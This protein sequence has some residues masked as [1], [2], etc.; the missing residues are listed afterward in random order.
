MSVANVPKVIALDE[1][2][3]FPQFH[4]LPP[5]LRLHIWKYALP[6]GRTLRVKVDAY[7]DSRVSLL[8]NF[9]AIPTI[10]HVNLEARQLALSIC[11]NG[12][13]PDTEESD[14]YWNPNT[15]TVYFP[16]SASWTNGI[17][18]QHLFKDNVPSSHRN[19]GIMPVVQ[20]VAFP[21]NVW[22]AQGLYL[23]P[24][25]ACWLL[26]WLHQ[27]PSLKSLTLL[28]EP[29]DQWV[30]LPNTSIIY[31]SPLDIPVQQLLNTKPSVITSQVKK[32]LEAY[33]VTI[34][35]N[36]IPP[37]VDVLVLGMKKFK[38]NEYCI[39][40]RSNLD[41]EDVTGVYEIGVSKEERSARILVNRW[42]AEIHALSRWSMMGREDEEEEEGPEF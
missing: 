9:S 38:T 36:W 11:R 30:G 16:P 10:F 8:G 35:P 34:D 3:L 15:D 2:P 14:F 25:P 17:L 33:R 42:P 40:Q 5:E 41:R 21:L 19:G 6:N 24:L 23:E 29:Y 7:D 27:F 22:L 13:G 12:L 37:V 32:S 4:N 26:D 1:E 28:I 20:H 39:R 31:Y 18:E